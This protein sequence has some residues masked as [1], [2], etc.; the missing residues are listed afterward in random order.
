MKKISFLVVSMLLASGVFAQFKLPAASP[1]QTIIQDFGLSKITITYARPGI[2]GRAMIGAQVPWGEVWRTGANSATLITFGSPVV[3]LG[4]KVD[5]GTYALYTVPMEDGNWSFI[6]NSGIH[7]W[8][9]NGYKASEDLFRVPVKAHKYATQTETLAIQFTNVEQE[10]CNLN[11]R[12]DNYGVDIP[13]KIIIHEQLRKNL[14]AA[15]N[16]D[17]PRKPYFEAAQYYNE[18]EHNPQ[19]AL[20]MVDKAITQTDKPQ[21]FV[22][23]YKAK[24]QQELGDL[25]GAMATSQWSMKLSQEADATNYTIL[26]TFLQEQLRQN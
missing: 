26:N 16:S 8:G 9:V 23:Y 19:K 4:Q 6:L 20:E 22:I 17:N 14:E 24:L 2:K 11:I 10:S 25:K 21:F 15:L 1:T 12:W 18:W 5:S 13:I 7:N 3:V